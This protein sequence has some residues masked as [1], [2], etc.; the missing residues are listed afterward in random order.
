M[1]IFGDR[2]KNRRLQLGLTL[3]ELADRV[4]YK[5]RSSVTRVEQGEVEATFEK[6]DAFAKALNT[7]RSYLVG[8][9]DDPD[10]EVREMVAG[11]GF[12]RLR[13]PD[14][15]REMHL[16]KEFQM[17]HYASD[18]VFIDPEANTSEG[19]AEPYYLDPE[20]AE[21]A[22]E[23]Y[24]DKELRALFDAARDISPEDMKTLYSVALAMKRKERGE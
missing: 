13:S 10:E 17:G 19:P 1:S 6:I 16:R 9:V 12:L 4:G 5:H 20:T 3:Q 15:V 14:E 22:Q 24:E 23:I 18:H 11:D 21:I 2:V 7:S 8:W